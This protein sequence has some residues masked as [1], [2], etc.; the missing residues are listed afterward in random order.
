MFHSSKMQITINY[1][2]MTLV[3]ILEVGLNSK[4]INL[5]SIE[6]EVPLAEDPKDPK[7]I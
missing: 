3:E 5:S 6:M 2:Y 7:D 1:K 4:N